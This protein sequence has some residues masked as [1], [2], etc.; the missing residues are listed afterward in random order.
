[1]PGTCTTC[2]QTKEYGHRDPD[3]FMWFCEDCWMA[4]GG[5][6]RRCA[7]CKVPKDEGHV[8]QSV[9]YW[10]CLPCWQLRRAPPPPGY[11]LPPPPPH[12]HLPPVPGYPPPGGYPPIG[13]PGYP[14]PR[15]PSRSRS[16]SP[17]DRG[18]RGA[19]RR[20]ASGRGEDSGRGGFRPYHSQNVPKESDLAAEFNTDDP[21]TT[22][23]LRN[24]PNKF[25][26]INL[27]EEIDNE[28]FSGKYNFFY[29][30]MDVRNKTNVG[31][32]FINFVDSADMASFKAHF[33]GYHYKRHQ[34]QKIA[35]VSPAHVQGLERNIQ[36]LAK[37][38]VSQFNESSYR[39]LV[40]QDGVQMDWDD[41]VKEYS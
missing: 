11:G 9:E 20:K 16:R 34:S 24:I 35:T 28:G 27:M 12:W 8:D 10:Y 41:A 22:A 7:M 31:Y 33:E 6:R 4:A 39:P 13:Y 32:A 38:A 5:R 26:Q 2:R 19:R 14:P 37:K 17:R 3:N 36:Q 1:M 29:L 15:V 18:G 23:M 25:S 40:L 21:P 30:P